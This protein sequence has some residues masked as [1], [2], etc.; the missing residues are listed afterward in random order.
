MWLILLYVIYESCQENKPKEF[1]RIIGVKQQILLANNNQKRKN[2]FVGMR[3]FQ[4][5]NSDSMLICILSQ[6]EIKERGLVRHM[7]P[8]LIITRKKL[9]L[10]LYLYEMMDIH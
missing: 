2:G 7:T 8:Y 3:Y 4:K 10:I 1:I 9:F 5:L 6:Q